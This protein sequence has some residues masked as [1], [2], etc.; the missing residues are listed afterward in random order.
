MQATSQFAGKALKMVTLRFHHLNVLLILF[1]NK[2]KE[3][4]QVCCTDAYIKVLIIEMN[5]LGGGVSMTY[6]HFQHF[7]AIYSYL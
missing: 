2:T 7:R 1:E 5:S 4:K 6:H 3:L